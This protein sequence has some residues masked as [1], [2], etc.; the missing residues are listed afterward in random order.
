MALSLLNATLVSSTPSLPTGRRRPQHM[1]TPRHD[2]PTIN[3]ACQPEAGTSA[4]FVAAKRSA[5]GG[6]IVAAPSILHDQWMLIGRQIDTGLGGR[7]DLLAIAPDGALVFI[8]L[9]RER[10]PRDVVAQAIEY[11]TFVSDLQPEVIA[12]IY[13]GCANGR[14]LGADFQARFGQALDEEALNASH[15]NVLVA[16]SIEDSTS[17]I[18]RYLSERDIAINVLC[19]QV[20]F[21]GEERLLSRA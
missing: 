10:T 21:S 3:M 4:T 19:F 6:V 12:A 16:S 9:K 11:A 5:V 20:F 8:E 1:R 17:R 18:V 7:L 2:D 15:Q 13:A 14:D